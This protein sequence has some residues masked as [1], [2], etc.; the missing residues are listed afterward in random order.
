MRFFAAVLLL[1]G[2]APSFAQ[3]QDRRI[4]ESIHSRVLGEDRSIWVHVPQRLAAGGR[5]PVVYVLDAEAQFDNVIAVLRAMQ[6]EYS[7]ASQIVVVGVGNIWLRDRDY[8]PTRVE[9][10]PRMDAA[11][12]ATTGGGPRFIAFLEKELIPHVSA[13]YPVTATRIIVGHSLGG[14]I[15]MQML[16][17]QPALFDHYIVVDP[18]LW[19]D[20]RRLLTDMEARVRTQQFEGR[21]LF[22]AVANV[23]RRNMTEKQIRAERGAVTELIRPS[24][25]LADLLSR[26]DRGLRFQYRFYP[27]EEHLSV[28]RPAAEDGM[29]FVLAGLDPFGY[30]W[31]ISQPTAN[32]RRE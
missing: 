18:S 12:A 22:L 30:E 19:W 5:G 17:T 21:S 29:K 31:K 11:A 24:L 16:W 10:S 3:Q 2:I 20:E 28:F 8:T 4:T 26:D 15:A 6:R 7:A 9:S 13:K 14:L 27:R 23:S 25:M 1:A 32:I